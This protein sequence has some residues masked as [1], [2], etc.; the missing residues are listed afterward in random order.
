MDAWL[1]RAAKKSP[2]QKCLPGMSPKRESPK[3]EF[4]KIESPKKGMTPKKESTPKKQVTP[5]K[6]LTPMHQSPKREVPQQEPGTD[7]VKKESVAKIESKMRS[8]GLR[9]GAP[10]KKP[11]KRKRTGADSAMA[12]APA[13][14]AKPA[15]PGGK[16]I[17]QHRRTWGDAVKANIH[18]EKWCINAKTH[19]VI[20][21]VEHSA[22]E[23]LVLPNASSVVPANFNNKTPVV[24]ASVTSTAAMGEIFGKS[25]I[26]GGTRMGSWHANKGEIVYFP[27][28][29]TMRV[30]W[31]MSG[32]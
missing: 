23:E 15:K 19:C 29:R 28:T 18:V 22:F 2:P 7:C 16:T 10:A 17:E 3:K 27:P 26:S 13:K 9:L 4:V 6:E 25:K 5:K 21:D 24:V 1:A 12:A 31:I 32:W 30:W 14:K 20:E 8:L 11:A